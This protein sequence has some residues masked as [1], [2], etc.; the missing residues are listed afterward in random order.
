M[1]T[2]DEEFTAAHA[3]VHGA[4]GAGR[5]AVLRLAE[6]DPDAH[7]HAPE[8][9]ERAP[10]AADISSEYDVYGSGMMELDGMSASILKL[11]DELKIADNTIVI[12][13][14]DNGAMVVVAGRRH[15]AVPRREGHHLGRRR[16]R[17]D[18]G[19]LAR[20]GSP[21][22]VSNGIQSTSTCSPRSPRPPGAGDVASE[23]A[24]VAQGPHRRRGQ[25]RTLDRQRAF[26]RATRSS[27]TT[28]AS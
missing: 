8:A 26:A 13:T 17:A 15:H 6:H 7:L 3:A 21:G 22:K 28:R 5:Q 23:T 11:L 27:T 25:P 24:R 12:F 4:L 2:V 9:R 14:T 19:A 1:E 10:G 16:A 20:P 18:A